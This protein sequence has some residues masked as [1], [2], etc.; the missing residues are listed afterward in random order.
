[1]LARQA[2]LHDRQC[3]VGRFHFLLF[4]FDRSVHFVVPL[5]G[6]HPFAERS[7]R[8]RHLADQVG[9]EFGIARVLEK[10]SVRAIGNVIDV[11]IGQPT[12][13]TGIAQ[14]LPSGGPVGFAF[15][16]NAHG[17]H[18]HHHL[19]RRTLVHA[20]FGNVGLVQ[21]RDVCHRFFEHG[22]DTLQIE[23]GQRG[24]TFDH[25]RVLSYFLLLDFDD[26]FDLDDGS[27]ILL[28]SAQQLFDFLQ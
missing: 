7:T 20:N 6:E 27:L 23:L 15:E 25:V 8:R 14:H 22:L 21:L 24:V 1:M 26:F 16:K 2:L 18:D 12:D 19:V 11:Q 4:R 13:E 28:Q 17:A 3:L 9:S 5:N 10:L